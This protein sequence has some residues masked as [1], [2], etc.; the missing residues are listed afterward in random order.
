MKLSQK[1]KI[2]VM[3]DLILTSFLIISRTKE[4]EIKLG[5]P[6]IKLSIFVHIN[7]SHS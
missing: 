7:T 2:Y 5:F 6:H 1:A 3:S 4:Q